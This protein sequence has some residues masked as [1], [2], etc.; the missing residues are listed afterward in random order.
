MS[1]LLQEDKSRSAFGRVN[2][3]F[4]L[5]GCDRS[6]DV[7]TVVEKSLVR[8][9]PGSGGFD[10]GSVV[11][12]P[13]YRDLECDSCEAHTIKYR[14]DENHF[15]TKVPAAFSIK[16]NIKSH[17]DL[18]QRLTD[19]IHVCVQSAF[20]RP[21]FDKEDTL[22]HL[23]GDLLI[24]A[25]QGGKVVGFSTSVYG[26]PRDVLENTTF[27]GQDG[28]YLAAG[29]VSQEAKAS[30]I[31]QAMVLQRIVAGIA[32]GNSLVF[33]RTQN[34]LVEQS[35][36]GAL[37]LLKNTGD[38]FDCTLHRVK[39]PKLYGGMLAGSGQT[40][41]IPNIQQAYADLDVMAG[42]AYVLLFNLKKGK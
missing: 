10:P 28:V 16:E 7:T 29:A 23:S 4:H 21:D 8:Y 15:E 41:Q 6:G 30:G 38:I 42:D 11:S 5:S 22:H 1:L 37:R 17:T 2:S 27:P 20:G 26:S 24:T 32:K 19:Q 25:H 3:T 39:L 13:S 18:E 9:V 31:Y 12:L 34:P 14:E 35:I 36:V 33:T 40:S